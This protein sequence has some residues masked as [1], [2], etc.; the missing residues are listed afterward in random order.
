[1]KK[2][3][4]AQTYE[5]YDHYG[6]KTMYPF[7]GK[8]IIEYDGGPGAI[9][10]IVKSRNGRYVWRNKVDTGDPHIFNSF[11]DALTVQQEVGGEIL[12]AKDYFGY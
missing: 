12:P 3:I 7:K 8:A 1:M 10:V 5:G 4:K 2:Y 6:S 9:E 11:K